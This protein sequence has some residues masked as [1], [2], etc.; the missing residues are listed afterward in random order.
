MKT[1]I[2]NRSYFDHMRNNSIIQEE[3]NSLTSI[4]RLLSDFL[5]VSNNISFRNNTTNTF[6]DILETLQNNDD[7]FLVYSDLEHPCIQNAIDN[8]HP[9]EKTI[10]LKLYDLLLDGQIKK[11]EKEISKNYNSK[12]IYLV[13]HVLWNSGIIIDIETITERIKEYN[14]EN[15]VIIDGAQSVGNVEK[16]FSENFNK[17]Y[18]DFY[19]GCTHKW[20]GTKN[21][22]GFVILGESII[23]NHRS[24]VD[25]IFLKDIFSFFAG[26]SD[27]SESKFGMS[28]YDLNLLLQITKE[29][30]Q[31]INSFEY[32]NVD[33][34]RYA[35]MEVIS[36]P[37][38]ANEAK[39]SRFFSYY[40][41]NENLIKSLEV[42]SHYDTSIVSDENLPNNYSWLR[43]GK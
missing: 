22:M 17:S 10:C 43:I 34:Y 39:I 3:L 9:K 20:I 41:T 42:F 24:I 14:P 21:L 19:I 11:I 30:N 27:F 25:R 26:L 2:L 5:N 8:F 40:G 36:I 33:F 15:I 23:K 4:R 31:I 7:Y 18:I 38:F 32:P 28:T 29:L 37:Y 12:S 1:D 35:S 16:L 6:I 13:S